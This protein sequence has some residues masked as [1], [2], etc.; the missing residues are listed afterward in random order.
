MNE[1]FIKI[2]H[3]VNEYTNQIN[4]DL[5]HIGHIVSIALPKIIEEVGSKLKH[6][7]M[8]VVAQELLKETL[9]QQYEMWLVYIN[10]IP[11]SY[12]F[13]KKLAIH[14]MNAFAEQ[15][16]I[17]KFRNDPTCVYRSEHIDDEQIV[18]TAKS[19]RPIYINPITERVGFI[20]IQSVSNVK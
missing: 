2:I 11:V 16:K 12:T 3:H 5:D 7:Q 8:E 19:M 13:T 14:R 9:N 10:D 6:S 18:I 4:Q 20:S 17:R 1:S 15:M